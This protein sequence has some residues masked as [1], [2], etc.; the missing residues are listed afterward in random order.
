MVNRGYGKPPGTKLSGNTGDV[1]VFQEI[2]IKIYKASFREL[3]KMPF[4]DAV[5][6]NLSALNPVW[7]GS[8]AVRSMFMSLVQLF[9]QVLTTDEKCKLDCELRLYDTFDMPQ[10]ISCISDVCTYWWKVGHL[11]DETGILIFGVLS[12]LRAPDKVR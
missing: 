8:I 2:V 12:K 5:L 10:H 3:V 4:D 11:K 1:Q 7:Q 9:P 6:V